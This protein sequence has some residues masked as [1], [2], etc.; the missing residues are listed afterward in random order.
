MDQAL[1]DALVDWLRIPSISTGEG[2]PADL[3]RGAR[4][5]ADR[6]RAAGGTADLVTI[7]GGNPLVVDELAPAAPGAPAVLIYGHYD[8]QGIG[9][10][11][12]WTTPA[13]EPTVR[14]G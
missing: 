6:V 1:L 8:V 13:F 2:D 12:A 3:E 9:D 11:A 4:W 7:D 14:D 10:G 5:A